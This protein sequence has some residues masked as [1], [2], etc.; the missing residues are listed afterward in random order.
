M[1]FGRDWAQT[2]VPFLT[3]E[4]GSFSSN[5]AIRHCHLCNRQL[6]YWHP[7]LHIGRLLSSLEVTVSIM[8]EQTCEIPPKLAIAKDH[9]FVYILY[10][11]CILNNLLVHSTFVYVIVND[12]SCRYSCHIVLFL[13]I[14][15][16]LFKNLSTKWVPLKTKNVS[17]EKFLE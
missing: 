6:S 16:K 13:Q 8:A 12:S 4:I 2:L 11:T 1:N 3:W 17:L 15:F 10:S 7:L 9:C 5:L 14:C